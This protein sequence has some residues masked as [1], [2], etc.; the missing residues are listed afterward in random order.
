MLLNFPQGPHLQL[1]PSIVNLPST[2]K[3]PNDLLSLLLRSIGVYFNI[4]YQSHSASGMFL[5]SPYAASS[6]VNKHCELAINEQ[7][8][9]YSSYF[10]IQIRI[11]LD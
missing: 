1:S 6:A 9:E 4:K 7:V 3:S 11:D 5:N 10:V 8:A 2:N